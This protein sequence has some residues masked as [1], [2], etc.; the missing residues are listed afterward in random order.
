M[1]WDPINIFSICWIL[2]IG[3]PDARL[4]VKEIIESREAV[5][6]VNSISRDVKL[7]EEYVLKD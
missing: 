1:I 6:I 7:R 5:I 3:L 2:N 4:T